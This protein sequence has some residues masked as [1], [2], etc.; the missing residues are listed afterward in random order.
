MVGLDQTP[1][2]TLAILPIPAG[3]GLSCPKCSYVLGSLA[4][5]CNQ[6]GTVMPKSEKHLDKREVD[7]RRRETCSLS[8]HSYQ[9]VLVK[10]R[11]CAQCGEPIGYVH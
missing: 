6:C 11:F 10:A 2:E 1:E 3:M 5:Y 9:V 4:K 8:G 7:E